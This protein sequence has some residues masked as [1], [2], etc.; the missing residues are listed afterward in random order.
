MLE[1]SLSRSPSLPVFFC[2][3]EP[4]KSTR[5]SIEVRATFG[6]G[7]STIRTKEMVK[8]QWERLELWF[9]FV[10]ALWR[11]FWPEN[12]ENYARMKE[13]LLST[14][15]GKKRA[16]SSAFGHSPLLTSEHDSVGLIRIV[17]ADFLQPF[18]EN[19]TVGVVGKTKN[20]PLE[21]L[22]CKKMEG[23]CQG[24]AGR[25]ERIGACA[26]PA[27]FKSGLTFCRS[28]NLVQQVVDELVVDFGKRNPN[29]E[30]DISLALKE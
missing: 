25:S 29:G 20:S 6:D 11:F 4:A 17:D 28:G 14:I 26:F 15:D 10:A 27:N 9:N 8:M 16:A 12:R 24:C 30:F 19:V 18:D 13:S 7:A 2:L 23:G 1:L 3:S 5:C 22:L 21:F